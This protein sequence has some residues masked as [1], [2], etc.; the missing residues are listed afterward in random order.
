MLE[1]VEDATAQ[2]VVQ[3]CGFH[4]FGGSTTLMVGAGIRKIVNAVTRLVNPQR[5]IQV[6]QIDEEPLV[7]T[8]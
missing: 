6:L 2:S 8:S 3:A 4:L 7:E 5:K 1:T